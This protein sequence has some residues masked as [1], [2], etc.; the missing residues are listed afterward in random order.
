VNVGKSF[1][2]RF[3]ES[4]VA[5]DGTSGVAIAPTGTRIRGEQPDRVAYGSYNTVTD[6]RRDMEATSGV[7]SERP[8][9]SAAGEACA[10]VPGRS[11]TDTLTLTYV[12]DEAPRNDDLRKHSATVLPLAET[13][14]KTAI[15]GEQPDRGAAKG[16]GALPEKSVGTIANSTL[17]YTFVNAEQPRKDERRRAAL[18]LPT[19]S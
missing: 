14:T 2:L 13:G 11:A 7:P 19:C 17:T 10:A 8:D 9:R 15:K 5:P 18:V 3:Q 4:Q 16:Y 1:L 6:P 12:A